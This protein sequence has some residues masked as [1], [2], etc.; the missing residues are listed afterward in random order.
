MLAKGMLDTAVRITKELLAAGARVEVDPKED[1]VVFRVRC[2]GI[3]ANARLTDPGS[4][5][6]AEAFARELLNEVGKD[7]S[8]TG[9]MLTE[10]RLQVRQKQPVQIKLDGSERQL[11][12]IARHYRALGF[13]AMVKGDTLHIQETA[14]ARRPI[15]GTL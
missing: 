5:E 1:Q 15:D 8:P 3:W 11:D 13:I 12:V 2:N 14:Y 10:A 9:K 7:D 6:F 4:E